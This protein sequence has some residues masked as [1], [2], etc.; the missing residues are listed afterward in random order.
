MLLWALFFSAYKLF[1]TGR[2]FESGRKH[3]VDPVREPRRNVKMEEMGRLHSGFIQFSC[4]QSHCRLVDF[5]MP[6]PKTGLPFSVVYTP[7]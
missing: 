7:S 1:F 2:F 5:I 6:P 4:G 3:S